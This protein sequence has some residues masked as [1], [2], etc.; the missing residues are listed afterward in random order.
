MKKYTPILFMLCI[1]YSMYTISA[2]N[3]HSKTCAQCREIQYEIN[4]L[5]ALEQ[6]V[7]IENHL[8]YTNYLSVIKD[9]KQQ[10]R[11]LEASMHNSI[12][13]KTPKGIAP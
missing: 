3:T 12:T 5:S 10:I 9:L 11:E 1:S 13:S 7:A 4:R 6:L 8:K 2:D